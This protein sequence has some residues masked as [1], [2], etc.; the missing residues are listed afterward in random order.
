M[1]LFQ[2]GR[3][4]L[5]SGRES[6]F[7]IDCDALTDEDISTLADMILQ[8]VRPYSRVEGIPRGGLRLATFLA[9]YVCRHEPRILLV[10]DVLTTGGSMERRRKQLQA[11][12]PEH[13]IQGAVLFARGP[14]PGWIRPV[15]S[16][17][18]RVWEQ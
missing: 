15:L 6:T 8:L 1:N 2:S 18:Q 16:L 10:D 3:F 12:N 11:E 7:K 17:N 13:S 14:C 4:T 5:N 9:P